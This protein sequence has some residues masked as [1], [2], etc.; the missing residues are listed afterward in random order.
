MKNRLRKDAK[1]RVTENKP[2]L[3]MEKVPGLVVAPP[4]NNGNANQ[5][6]QP[7][8]TRQTTQQIQGGNAQR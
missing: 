5:K 3:G 4:V 2:M 6:P 8:Q 1:L 7:I